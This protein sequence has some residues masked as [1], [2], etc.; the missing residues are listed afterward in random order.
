[1]CI[2]ILFKNVTIARQQPYLL[3]VRTC[4]IAGWQ[5]AIDDIVYTFV[6]QRCIIFMSR[7]PFEYPT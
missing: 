5:V 6:M 2:E 3:L 7:V 1:M 4:N